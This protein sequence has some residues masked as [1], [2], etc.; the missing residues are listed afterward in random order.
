MDQFGVL[1]NRKRAVIALIHSIVFLGVASFGFV[2]P[3]VGILH[4]SG[5]R[6]DFAL[7]GIYLVVSSILFWLITISRPVVE[8]V[9]FSIC[10]A[11]AMAGLVRTIFGDRAI[12]SAQHVRVL[13]LSFAVAIGFGIVRGYSRTA[14]AAASARLSAEGSQN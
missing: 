13:M 12:P 14:V 5:A 2:S 6:G 11:S 7:A 3:K 4:G 8:R 10:A 1:T 9:Y